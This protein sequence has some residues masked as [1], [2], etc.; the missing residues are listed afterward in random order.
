MSEMPVTM[1]IGM[2]AAFLGAIVAFGSMAWAWNGSVDS[3]ALVG[4]DMAAAMMFFAVVGSFTTYSPVRGNTVVVLAALATAMPIVAGI[5]GAMSVF[6]ALVCIVL[7]LVCI[8]IASFA[9]TRDYVDAN[10]VI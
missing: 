5:F 3:A 8:G 6:F 9:S 4:L 7:G 2:A 10:R 1:K